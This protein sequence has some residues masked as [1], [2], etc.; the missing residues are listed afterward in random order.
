MLFPVHPRT[1]DR[2]RSAGLWDELSALPGARLVD[3]L[4]YAAMLRALAACAVAV[5]DSGGL[6]EEASYLG[7]PVVVHAPHDPALG[8]CRDRRRRAVPA[9]TPRACSRRSTEL[10]DARRAG[11]GRRPAVSR[12]ATAARR[13]TSSRLLADDD[14]RALLTPREPELASGPFS[15]ASRAWPCADLPVRGGAASTSTTR[16]SRRRSGWPAPGAAVADRAAA[17]GLDGAALHRVLARIAAEGSDRG[18]IIDRAL[19]AIGV[20]PRPSRRLPSSP[21]SAGTRRTA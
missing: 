14:L 15:V 6:Q 4:P 16:C 2:L 18:G 13:R 17:A 8:R 9:S 5:T 3:P 10:T 1:R 7:V 20:H 11:P 12:T 21:R 19:A